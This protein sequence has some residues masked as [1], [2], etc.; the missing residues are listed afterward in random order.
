MKINFYET[1]KNMCLLKLGAYA[2]SRGVSET[3]LRRMLGGEYPSEGGPQFNR[4]IAHLREDGYLVEEP[5]TQD[6]ATEGA[7]E[8]LQC[9]GGL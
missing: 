9:C 7:G 8:S 2:R 3:T 5:D 6:D 1:K 4:I